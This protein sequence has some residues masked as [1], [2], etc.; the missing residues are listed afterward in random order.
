MDIS[1]RFRGVTL[2]AIA[3]DRRPPEDLP[4]ESPRQPAFGQLVALA[5]GHPSA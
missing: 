1:S 4:N 5:D 3:A 2:A